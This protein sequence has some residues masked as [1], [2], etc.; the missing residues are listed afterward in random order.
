MK[1]TKKKRCLIDRLGFLKQ[2][3]KQTNQKVDLLNLMKKQK[4]KEEKKIN[5]DGNRVLSKVML[6]DKCF[7]N[8]FTEPYN[9]KYQIS[10]HIVIKQ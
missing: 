7:V 5:K 6:P 10:V 9:L 3:V 2:A 4:T 8:L 1:Q